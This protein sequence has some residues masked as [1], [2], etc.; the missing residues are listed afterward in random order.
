M[1]A[2]I[3]RTMKAAI[4]AVILPLTLLLNA[5][6]LG[7]PARE[8]VVSY[9]FGPQRGQVQ[10]VPGTKATLMV[11]AAVAPSWLDTRGIVYRLVYLDAARPQI[12][13]QSRWVDS[14][15]ALFTQRVRS[16]FAAVI[17]VVGSGDGARADFTLQIEIE[18]FS[19][20][21]ATANRSQ[22]VIRIRVTLINQA[23][24][25]LHAQRTFS[26]ER[27]AGPDAEGAAR[28]LAQAADAV[29]ESLLEWTMQNLNAG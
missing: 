1:H 4:C 3:H 10:A 28:A 8:P 14:P 11:P 6:S 15:A 25:T 12:Y 26:V 21:F 5:C 19:Q 2:H 20:A 9:D 7:P 23:S 18:D 27:S 22:A 17:P 13:A 24:R 16:R 29:I